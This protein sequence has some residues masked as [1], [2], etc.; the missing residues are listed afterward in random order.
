MMLL[1]GWMK[2][3]NDRAPRAESVR[4][5]AE[6]SVYAS[7][8]HI[9]NRGVVQV[10]ALTP[11]FLVSTPFSAVVSHVRGQVMDCTR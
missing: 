8:Q 5:A 2:R 11:P 3:V 7:W 6:L 1:A 9:G 10:I 4:G